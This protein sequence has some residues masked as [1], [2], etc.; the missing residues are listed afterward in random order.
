MWPFCPS[1]G[2]VSL[3][4]KL[5][6]LHVMLQLLQASTAAAWSELTGLL[7][8]FGRTVCPLGCARKSRPLTASKLPGSTW[9]SGPVAAEIC[10]RL[11]KH[12]VHP[13]QNPVAAADLFP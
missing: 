2:G 9:S 4:W 6:P 10:L 3:A 13:C 5:W 8:S 12:P 1:K 11:Q 7:V